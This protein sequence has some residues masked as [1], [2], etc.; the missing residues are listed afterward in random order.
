MANFNIDQAEGLRRMLAGP[1]PRIVTLLS[2]LGTAEKNAMLTN[3]TASLA[4]LGSDALLVDARRTD[5]VGM[6]LGRMRR[7][8]LLEVARQQ[9]A[10]NEVIQ[11]APQGF[12]F[13]AMIGRQVASIHDNAADNHRLS[14]IF[15]VLAQQYGTMVVDAELDAED[16]LPVTAMAEGEIV[17][18]ITTSAESIKAGYSL[19]KRLQANLGRRSFGVLV[20]HADEAQAQ[21]VYANLAQTASRYLAVP[22]HFMGSIPAD[23]H[24]SRAA[25][26][27]RSVI[28]AFPMALASVAFRRIAGQLG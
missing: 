9:C 27:G 17:V 16:R 21:L 3:L 19:I 11:S 18:H 10:L 24:L 26:L 4:H 23:D 8:G 28:D 14:N 13:A 1:R 7:N 25:R 20:T 5:G 15:N 12:S 22:L 2:V 6:H